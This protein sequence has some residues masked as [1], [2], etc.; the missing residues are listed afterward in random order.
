MGGATVQLPFSPPGEEMWFWSCS[1]PSAL[2]SMRLQERWTGS[3]GEVLKKAVHSYRGVNKGG[4]T[5]AEG[6][7]FVILG[8][9]GLPKPPYNMHLNPPIALR[10][11]FGT[12]I[13]R[14]PKAF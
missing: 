4:Y 11:H 12:T 2:N 3:V 1:E 10:M 14:K 9:G 7:A 5:G 8:G 13:S 6:V